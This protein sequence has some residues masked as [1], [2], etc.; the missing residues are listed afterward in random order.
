MKIE[1]EVPIDYSS[2]IDEALRHL[3]EEVCEIFGVDSIKFKIV[4]DSNPTNS[5]QITGWYNERRL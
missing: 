2:N 3:K 1:I 5:T 4:V